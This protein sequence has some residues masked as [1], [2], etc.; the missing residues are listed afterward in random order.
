L[1]I[2]VIRRYPREHIADKR[3]KTDGVGRGELKHREIDLSSLSFEQQQH[4]QQQ[5]QALQGKDH[6]WV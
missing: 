3:V 4:Q 6:I 2:D 5:Q 1:V